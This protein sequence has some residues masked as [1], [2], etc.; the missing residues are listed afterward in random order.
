MRSPV[1]AEPGGSRW[2]A[3][4][5]RSTATA[6]CRSSWQTQRRPLHGQGHEHDE[7]GQVEGGDDG[8]VP[9]GEGEI[10]PGYELP[11]CVCSS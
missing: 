7:E 1:A 9:G 2:S 8:G 5:A 3:A 4:I 10:E 11:F 6:G